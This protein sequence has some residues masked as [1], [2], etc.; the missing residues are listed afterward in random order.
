MGNQEHIERLD[1]RAIDRVSGPS[2]EP[3]RSVFLDVSR[4][5]LGV[6][7]EA[8]SQ[9]TTIYVKFSTG[10][11]GTNV[12]A[13]VW[14]RSSKEIVIGFSIPTDF[15]ASQLGDAPPKTKYKGLTR[16]LSLNPG[17]PIPLEL[18]EWARLAYTNAS[19]KRGGE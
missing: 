16:Y 2:W 14:L 6:A 12:F 1:S 13:V 18:G 11:D 7:P 3:L 4:I 9:L 5:F 17:Q 15:H 19:S 8:Q 10:S